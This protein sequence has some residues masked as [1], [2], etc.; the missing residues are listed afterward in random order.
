MFLADLFV[1]VFD[2]RHSE[3]LGV[4]TQTIFSH[5]IETLER[6]SY[7]QMQRYRIDAQQVQSMQL[8]LVAS[9]RSHFIMKQN[10]SK[11]LMKHMPQTPLY[12]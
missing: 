4:K 10:T 5:T 12:V 11:Q 6:V 9:P 1:A 3:E 7:W 2:I 8:V